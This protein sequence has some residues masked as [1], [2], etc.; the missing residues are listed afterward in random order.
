M[1]SVSPSL[2]LHTKPAQ[3][4][5]HTAGLGPS[6]YWRPVAATLLPLLPFRGLCEERGRSLCLPQRSG[7]CLPPPWN[8]FP[9]ACSPSPIFSDPEGTDPSGVACAELREL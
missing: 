1:I 9:V 3:A 8:C 6:T 4:R 7:S 5:G 2:L